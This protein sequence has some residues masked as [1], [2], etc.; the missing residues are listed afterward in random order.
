MSKSPCSFLGLAVVSFYVAW[1][2][3]SRTLVLTSLVCWLF[4]LKEVLFET[5]CQTTEINF[6]ML[7]YSFLIGMRTNATKSGDN[8]I[9]NGRKMWIT[10]ATSDGQSTGDAFLIYARTGEG[11]ADISSFLVKKD[12]PGFSLGQVIKVHFHVS[13]SLVSKVYL[14]RRL[15]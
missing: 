2:C 4:K 5:T 10:N 12:S 3:Q 14:T 15:S 1:E 6:K 11:R 9:L 8:Y 13:W 7:C